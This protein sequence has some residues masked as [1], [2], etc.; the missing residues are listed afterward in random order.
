MDLLTMDT[1]IMR[2]GILGS[3]SVRTSYLAKK[4]EFEW[5]VLVCIRHTQIGSFG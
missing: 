2:S 1:K 5:K 3:N 4:W